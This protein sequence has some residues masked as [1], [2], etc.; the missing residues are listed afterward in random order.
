MLFLMTFL[1]Y[2]IKICGELISSAYLAKTNTFMEHINHVLLFKLY[3]T[4]KSYTMIS[5]SL[6]NYYDVDYN[7]T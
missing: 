2:L 4:S 7:V 6:I 3:D 1:I 5:V